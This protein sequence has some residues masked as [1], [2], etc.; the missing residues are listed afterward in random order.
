MAM[1]I[2]V[3]GLDGSGVSYID[4]SVVSPLSSAFPAQRGRGAI[5]AVELVEHTRKLKAQSKQPGGRGLPAHV[6]P[7]RNAAIDLLI[8]PGLKGAVRGK[9]RKYENLVRQISD[10]ND[11]ATGSLTPFCLSTG[12]TLH[13]TAHKVLS[14]LAQCLFDAKSHTAYDFSTVTCNLRTKSYF[15][16]SMF[17]HLSCALVRKTALFFRKTTVLHR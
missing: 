16:S 5:S 6:D 10:N 17:K 12:G 3:D 13:K 11:M 9:E 4:V 7:T 1:D 15:A 8:N 2:V 14:D